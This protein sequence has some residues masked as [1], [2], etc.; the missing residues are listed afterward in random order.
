MIYHDV[1]ALNTI[2]ARVGR[3]SEAHFLCH[4][5]ET[6]KMDRTDT[7][8]L[9]T[10]YP[11]NSL[12]YQ[13]GSHADGL[14][15]L[16]EGEVEITLP[17]EHRES[18][19]T[20]LK[21]GEMFGDV[22]LFTTS[23]QRFTSART[24]S[25]S[26]ILKIDERTFIRQLH[27][28]ASLAFR[29]IRLMAQRVYDLNQFCIQ[30]R[31]PD[32]VPD[33]IGTEKDTRDD[34][35]HGAIPNVFD[36]SVR[37]HVLA[38]EDDP[39]YFKLLK[40]CLDRATREAGDSPLAPDFRLT[41][42]TTLHDGLTQMH[43]NKYDLVLL[44]LNLPDSRGL[45]TVQAVLHGCPDTPVVV[46]S[47]CHDAA[48]S[49]A[50]MAGGVQDILVKG[51]EKAR[52]IEALKYAIIRHN[53]Q[54]NPIPERQGTSLTDDLHTWMRHMLDKLRTWLPTVRPHHGP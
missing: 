24:L 36:F 6:F 7:R 14:F 48:L 35:T 46:L 26:R 49:T 37:Y 45:D 51:H 1:T 3:T 13:K 15:V 12:I 19:I 29:M 25:D 28:D 16:Q 41:N 44:D 9:G 33:S 23:R 8:S 54:E 30:Q 32:S 2:L 34:I 11:K 27:V 4:L 18:R 21:Q 20:T 39:D 53:R 40:K 47:A 10:F 31:L 50:A 38:I 42:A 52:I 43:K 5:G 22:A 17:V